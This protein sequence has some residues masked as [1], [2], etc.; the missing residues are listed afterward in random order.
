M[1]RCKQHVAVAPVIHSAFHIAAIRS[2][3]HPGHIWKAAVQ[4]IQQRQ[5]SASSSARRGR[6][7]IAPHLRSLA[8]DNLTSPSC[9]FIMKF[10]PMLTRTPQSRVHSAHPRRCR[11]DQSQYGFRY[12][13]PV[14]GRLAVMDPLGEDGGM[15]SY[16]LLGNEALNSIDS[17]GLAG[18]HQEMPVEPVP[19]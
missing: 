19:P 13:I 6:E 17:L 9:A 8:S 5:S 12:Y 7:P 2:S 1:A 14:T 11:T 10:P 16:C 15:N 3:P 4:D 18:S